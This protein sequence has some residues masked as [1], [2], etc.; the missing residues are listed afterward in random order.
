MI[1]RKRFIL[2][3]MI[4][5]LLFTTPVLA[6]NAAVVE[7]AKEFSGS[8]AYNIPTETNDIKGWP[9]GPAIM[10]DSGVVMA[11]DTGTVIY[12][13][14][15]KEKRFPASTT[16]IMTVL[17]ALEHSNLTDSVTFTEDG[18]K[19]AV[20]GNSFVTPNLQ[21]GETLTMEQCLYA[22]MLISANEVSTQ[23]AQQIGGS[24]EGFTD[25]MNQKAAEIGCENTHFTN[26]NGLHDENHYTTAY[27]LAL[28]AKAAY[29]NEEFRKITGTKNYTIPPTN[30]FSEQRNMGNHH[31]LLNTSEWAY[32]GCV[33][34]KPGYTDAAQNTLVS[35]VE[36]NGILY[37]CV[38]MHYKGVQVVSDTI[39][40]MEYADKFQEVQVT[41][42]EY[43]KSGGK[44]VIPADAKAEDVTVVK[45]G[46]STEEQETLQFQG[47]TVGEAVVD[48]AAIL[49]AEEAAALEKQQ[50]EEAAAAAQKAEAEKQAQERETAHSRTLMLVS[51]V[52]CAAIL[53]GVAAIIASLVLRRK[54]RKRR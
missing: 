4:A 1:K 14:G 35:Y 29:E 51:I 36:K 22:I 52:L 5:S 47:Y 18:L 8:A 34:G 24:L 21:V 17:V 50:K 20:P 19:E 44:A 3:G 41:P 28:I 11:A 30:L 6:D 48:E 46:T 23:V 26:A 12:N 45:N 9:Q 15:M 39:L 43:T 54:G 7:H 49:A 13:K 37:I 31:A 2:F 27:D 32:E 16:K 38:T 42:A 10:C 53:I 25:L 40:L 33:G